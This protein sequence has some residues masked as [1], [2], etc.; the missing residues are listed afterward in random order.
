[1]I[2]DRARWCQQLA[3]EMVKAELSID[4]AAQ[5]WGL[6]RSTV[7]LLLRSDMVDRPLQVIEWMKLR[8]RSQRDPS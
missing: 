2:G 5:L 1:M 4:A 3:K 7:Q 8:S 6:K